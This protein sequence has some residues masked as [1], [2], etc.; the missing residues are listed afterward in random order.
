MI[1]L[2]VDINK[3]KKIVILSL[4]VSNNYFIASFKLNKFK[5]IITFNKILLEI[6]IEMKL[7]KLLTF[8]LIII[9]FF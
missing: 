4:S 8:F 1:N 6:E 2:N 9:Y 5:T 7:N 3:D